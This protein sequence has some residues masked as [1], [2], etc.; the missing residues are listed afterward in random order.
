LKGLAGDGRAFCFRVGALFS[1][2]TGRL[3]DSPSRPKIEAHRKHDQW[4]VVAVQPPLK[5]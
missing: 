1:R 5:A 3:G 4:R 2:K